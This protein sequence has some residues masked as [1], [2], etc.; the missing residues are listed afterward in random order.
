MSA[1]LCGLER[2]EEPAT[3]AI[4]H[5]GFRVRRVEKTR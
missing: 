2:D 1:Q 4:S 5:F 3:E